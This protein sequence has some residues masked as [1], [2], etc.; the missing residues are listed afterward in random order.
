MTRR[1]ADEVIDVLSLTKNDL[2]SKGF[3]FKDC[4]INL[5]R[6]GQKCQELGIDYFIDD[7]IIQ[8]EDVSKCGVKTILIDT[9]YNK[10]YKGLRAS[11]FQEVY[12]I[13]KG[14]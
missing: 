7:A 2:T 4:Y 13:I 12:N 1:S 10:E 9:W 5:S 3:K 8:I 11:G 6:K 14:E